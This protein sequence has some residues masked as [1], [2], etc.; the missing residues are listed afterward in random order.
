MFR[1]KLVS[2]KEKD[3]FDKALTV[4][5]AEEWGIPDIIEKID[6]HY[7]VSDSSRTGGVSDDGGGNAGGATRS[8]TILSK[9]NAE[10][11]TEIVERGLTIFAR[12]YR[13][14]NL[15]IFPEVLQNVANFDRALSAPHGSMVLAGRSGVGRRTAVSIVSALHGAI[16]LRSKSAGIIL[17]RVLKMI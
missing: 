7:F 15:V 8:K 12:E 5:V 4:L 10:E 17:S 13:N 6:S 14:L 2:L 9:V 3:N 11:M 16:P 1:D